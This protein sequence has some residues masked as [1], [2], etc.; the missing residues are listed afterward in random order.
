VRIEQRVTEPIL[1]LG[2][3]SL[4]A[5][6]IASAGSLALGSLLYGVEVY[7]PV[8]TQGVLGRSATA[9][10]LVIIPLTLGWTAASFAT[11]RRISRTGRYR[12]F[13][14]IGG[15][16]VLV[17]IASLTL[18]DSRTAPGAIAVALAVTGIGM[19]ATWPTYVISTQNAVEFARVGT[20]TAALQ[21]FRTMG[22]SLSVAALGALL[23]IRLRGELAMRVP[24]RHIDID[25]LIEGSGSIP[26]SLRHGVRLALAGSLRTVFL[27]L[28]PLAIAGLLLALRLKEQPLRASH[29]P[30]PLDAEAVAVA[31]AEGAP[32]GAL[33]TCPGSDE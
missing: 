10:G 2:L 33:L 18:I 1:P 14:I 8:F 19:G 5:F 24:G 17:G 30:L 12:R 23:T 13:P 9:S 29:E 21:F 20:A 32:N 11:G 28:V 31:P 26:P 16:I 25:G 15:T 22:A 7:V 4:S 6:A 3:F 27:A